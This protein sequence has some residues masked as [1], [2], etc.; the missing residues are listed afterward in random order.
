MLRSKPA[1]SAAAII[2]GAALAL[3]PA[4]AQ[5]APTSAPAPAEAASAEA[6]I[7][8]AESLSAA[9][10]HASSVALRSV[11]QIRSSQV[12]QRQVT[13]PRIDPFGMGIGPR[14][15]QELER[16]GLGS[17]F[18]VS[19]DGYII[20]N[21]HVIADATRLVVV[22][23]DDFEI[24]AKLVGAD[25]LTDLAVIRIDPAEASGRLVA[26]K[27]GDSNGVQVGDWVLAVGSPLEL[28][29]TVTAGIIS[30]TGRRQGIIRD[31][32]RQGYESFLQT[33]A[34]INPG[35]SGGPLVNLRG[36]VIGINTAI[37]STSGGSVGLGFAIP[38]A[39]AKNVVDQIIET[40]QVQRGYLG[41]QIGTF[42]P[43][44]AALLG[45]TDTTVRGAVVT[46]VEPGS[47]ADEA[48][49]EAN[50]VITEIN[51]VAVRDADDLRLQIAGVRPGQTTVVK[52]LRHEERMTFEVR[53]G[54]QRA[55]DAGAPA[56]QEALRTFG[57]AYAAPEAEALARLR[58]LPAHLR[59]GGAAVTRVE[60]EGP[61]A[62]AGFEVGDI[63]LAINNLRVDSPETLGSLLARARGGMRLEFTVA[64]GDGVLQ[65]KVLRVPDRRNR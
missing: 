54:D 61:A 50:D 26:A 58:G 47:P 9:F 57:F 21:N 49:M 31:R 38:T 62:D 36:E 25:P 43:D 16:R 55:A 32:R 53:V 48:G 45:H 64:T 28:D 5:P 14:R 40:G 27:I 59:R 7:S 20:T 30:A 6:A 65:T 19:E 11:V 22:F 4:W 46:F 3:S 60:D 1:A 18:V 63:V 37:K 34:A 52:A 10:R 56:L 35:N 2:A 51:G 24:E 8:V 23:S 42:T 12:V 44:A 17:G 15:T 29:E 33:D 13:D 39:I 41:V